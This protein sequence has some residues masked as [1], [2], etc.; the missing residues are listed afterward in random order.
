MVPLNKLEKYTFLKTLYFHLVKIVVVDIQNYYDCSINGTSHYS[1]TKG[2]NYCMLTP[3]LPYVSRIGSFLMLLLH[4][5][6]QTHPVTFS[7]FPTSSQSPSPGCPPQSL[8]ESAYSSS[9]LWAHWSH[10]FISPALLQQSLAF[11][12]LCGPFLFCSSQSSQSYLY[13][14]Q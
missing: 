8:S 2:L 7:C 4:G 9:P 13:R 5:R 10:H 14:G 11:L 6:P 12:W 1:C 3:L